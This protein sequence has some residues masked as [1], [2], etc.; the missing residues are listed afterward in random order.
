[1]DDYCNENLFV[2]D[3]FSDDAY[4]SQ[5][6]SVTE[7]R[8]NRR[9]SFHS[10]RIEEVPKNRAGLLGRFSHS[11]NYSFGLLFLYRTWKIM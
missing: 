6:D 4:H 1:M 2:I 7:H 5:E 3:I 10:H 9:L 11:F 8:G